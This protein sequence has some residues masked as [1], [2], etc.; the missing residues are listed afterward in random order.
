MGL[1]AIN[2]A[3]ADL[4]DAMGCDAALILLQAIGLQESRFIHRRQLIERDGNLVASGPAKSFWQGERLGGMTAGILRHNAT[5]GLT[6]A[7]CS[8]HGIAATPTAIWNAIENNDVLAASCARLLLWTDP[9]PLPGVGRRSDAFRYYVRTWR[10]GAYTN[11]SLVT[12]DA[13]MSK[14]GRNYFK[15]SELVLQ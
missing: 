15:A 13:L 8:L 4:P 1:N 9:A 7:L 10:P 12:K 14:F 6:R 11:G 5:A 2:A 3:L